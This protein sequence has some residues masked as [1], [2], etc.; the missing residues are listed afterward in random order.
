VSPDARQKPP[1][2]KRRAGGK[3]VLPT[4]FYGNGGTKFRKTAERHPMKRILLLA[5]TAERFFL[6]S[7]IS[8]SLFLM[9]QL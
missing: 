2:W 3:H 7:S 4:L 1:S 6:V 8:F 9:R 5:E